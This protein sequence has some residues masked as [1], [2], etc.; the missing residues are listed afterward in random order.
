MY[1][2]LPNGVI[3]TSNSR[4][5]W[6]F[7]LSIIF[8]SLRMYQKTKWLESVFPW[9]AEP[10]HSH[11]YSLYPSSVEKVQSQLESHVYI[12]CV[13]VRKNT[14]LTEAKSEALSRYCLVW[15][16]WYSLREQKSELALLASLKSDFL[17]LNVLL[18]H[19]S[20]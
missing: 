2:L 6:Q 18:R 8:C 4:W 7:F 19:M 10:L 20:R 14:N 5:F 17:H 1:L 16:G 3:L 9:A 11:S 15:V 13:T 12:Y